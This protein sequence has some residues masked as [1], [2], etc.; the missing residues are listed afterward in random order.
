M[1]QADMALGVLHSASTGKIRY[2]HKQATNLNIHRPAASA[3]R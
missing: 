1:R 3:F 2:N